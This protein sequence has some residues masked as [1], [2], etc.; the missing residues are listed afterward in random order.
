[1]SHVEDDHHLTGYQ[2]QIS[3]FIVLYKQQYSQLNHKHA[4]C[5][6]SR[7]KLTDFKA[8]LANSTRDIISI[9]NIKND[10]GSCNV[11]SNQSDAVPA[12]PLEGFGFGL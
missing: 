4:S 12:Y 1:M 11:E 10:K 2:T 8:I 9:L 7:G 6:L 3:S 5:T